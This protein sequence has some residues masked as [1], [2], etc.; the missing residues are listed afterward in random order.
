GEDAVARRAADGRAA[1]GVREGHALGGEAI[2]VRGRD[3]AV[4]IEGLHVAVAEI[5]G[6][7]E[8]DVGTVRGACG[9]VDAGGGERG[10]EEQGVGSHATMGVGPQTSGRAD[11]TVA[12]RRTGR[13]PDPQSLGPGDQMR[14]PYLYGTHRR[15][16]VA[17]PH[18]RAIASATAPK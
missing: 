15:T 7:H 9:A 18:R 14:L 16:M 8:H 4:W 11:R 17:Q 1:M 10:E 5:V 13:L 2:H 12:P 6:E 3:L